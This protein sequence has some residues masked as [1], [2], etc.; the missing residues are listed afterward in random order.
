MLKNPLK[1]SLFMF[2]IFI[3]FIVAYK[4]FQNGLN[5]SDFINFLEWLTL[6]VLPW[7][8]LYWFIK[9]VKQKK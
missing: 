9:Y 3:L 4:I 8:F 7:I 6:Y 5:L 1:V 2:G